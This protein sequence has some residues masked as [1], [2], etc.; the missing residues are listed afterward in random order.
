MNQSDRKW[1]NLRFCITSKH[2]E[3]KIVCKIKT[4]IENDTSTFIVWWYETQQ[5]QR[6]A[7]A[8]SIKASSKCFSLISSR[9]FAIDFLKANELL[10]VD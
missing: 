9:I 8:I 10:V 1:K 5:M 2:P 6:D 7:S 3:K 4:M